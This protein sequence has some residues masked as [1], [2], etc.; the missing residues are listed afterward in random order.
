MKVTRLGLPG[1]RSSCV[2]VTSETAWERVRECVQAALD[3]GKVEVGV[4]LIGMKNIVE[5]TIPTKGGDGVA[6]TVKV[7]QGS[8][9]VE[10]TKSC[11]GTSTPS[12]GDVQIYTTTK[13]HTTKLHRL[14]LTE[15]MLKDSNAGHPSS[16]FTCD[17]LMS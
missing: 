7:A 1:G 14:L 5:A 17:V 16:S 12:L 13:E 11:D 15:F 10:V 9:I 6:L 2:E 8:C 3:A 4:P